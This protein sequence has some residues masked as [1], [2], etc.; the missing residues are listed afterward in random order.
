VPA[1]VNLLQTT[2]PA[3]Q[4]RGTAALL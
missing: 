1:L 3:L 4:A 2:S